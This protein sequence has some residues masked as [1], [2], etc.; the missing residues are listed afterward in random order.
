MGYAIAEKYYERATDKRQ[1][2]QTLIELDYQDTTAVMAL[3]DASG[4]FDEP[5]AVYHQK[6]EQ[7]RPRVVAI[8]GLTNGDGQVS[9]GLRQFTV[10]FSQPMDTS[11]RSTDYGPMG[12]EY[13]VAIERIVLATDSLRATYH[14]KPLL[15]GRRYQLVVGSGY[16]T[17]S[18]VLPLVP[19]LIEFGTTVP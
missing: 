6:Y 3:A 14:L 13:S 17:A 11:F 4:Y 15:P 5:L 12:A 8:E 18:P 1:A 16:R 7:Q 2:I 9:P 19:Y 10:V